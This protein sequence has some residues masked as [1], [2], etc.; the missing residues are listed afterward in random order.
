MSEGRTNADCMPTTGS[1]A[2]IG[3]GGQCLIPIARS[4]Q[5]V[6]ARH[7]LL[8]A[9][10]HYTLQQHAGH[11]GDDLHSVPLNVQIVIS[12]LYG[13]DLSYAT[14]SS[15]PITAWVT[16]V[17]QLLPVVY[18]SWNSGEGYTLSAP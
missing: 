4:P 5:S 15:F 7:A 1:F 8:P 10:R 9:P 11:A 18:C 14:I 16:S 3:T 13:L 6:R 12:F 2:S 17:T